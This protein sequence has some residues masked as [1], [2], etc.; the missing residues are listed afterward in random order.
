LIVD[1]ADG[2]RTH[3]RKAKESREANEPMNNAGAHHAC[4]PSAE[5]RSFSARLGMH[6]ASAEE[7]AL[8]S[9]SQAAF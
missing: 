4:T 9:L 8:I 1:E 3:A 5:A 7:L 2:W 6:V